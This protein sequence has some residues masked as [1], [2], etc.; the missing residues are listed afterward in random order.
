MEK[1]KSADLHRFVVFADII[2]D[3]LS[4]K[5]KISPLGAQLRMK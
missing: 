4:S 1:Q 2:N 5:I 3:S